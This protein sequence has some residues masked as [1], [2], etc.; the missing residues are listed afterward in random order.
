MSCQVLFLVRVSVCLLVSVIIFSFN[1][2]ADHECEGGTFVKDHSSRGRR[3]V[4]VTGSQGLRDV[5]VTEPQG[6]HG[7]RESEPQELSIPISCMC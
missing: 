4:R 6:R 3:G 7:V 2:T 1:F 5:R